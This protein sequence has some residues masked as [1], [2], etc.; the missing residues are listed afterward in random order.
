M[1]D[2]VRAAVLTGPGNIEI[3]E[4]PYPKCPE[5]GAIIKMELAGICGTDKHTYKGEV[6]QF[7]GTPAETT[8]PFPII[9]G[10]ENVGIIVEI[11]EEGRH[12]LEYDGQILNV[13]DRVV[14]CP[15]VAC[16]ECWYCKHIADYPWCDTLLGYG[17][18][19]TC[20]E[21]PHLFGGF[22]EY[23][24]IVPGVKL[25]KVPDGMPPELAVFAELFDVTYSL[26]KAKEHYTF[27]GEGFAFGDTVMIQGAGPL[28]IMHMIK[29]RML[30]ADKV[31]M[32]DTSQFR[33]DIAKEFGA[34]VTMCTKDTTEAERIEI[35][36]QHTGGRGADVVVECAGEPE[37]FNEG[38][39]MARK[40][41]T[42]LIV[43]NYVDVG[44]TIEIKPNVF[45]AKN[46]RIFGVTNH[47]V[48]GY[49]PTM[50]M[51]MRYKDVYPFEKLI[52]H[53]Y[54]LEDA[55][56]AIKMAMDYSQSM[57]VLIDPWKNR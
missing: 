7:A 16:G 56:D 8:T 24:A 40:A 10:H 6:R 28:G 55:H 46:L 3:Q 29:A 2:S 38:V 33:L 41:G 13:G 49:A 15:D 30:G 12:K 47:P 51:M 31:I 37:V 44:R 32:S 9:Q 36:R 45:C 1:K 27:G 4:F 18:A 11:S 48:G 35:V 26:D 52:T 50:R 53:R 17:N 14:M 23:M 34:D 22:A 5:G 42:Y 20:A 25:Y 57:K 43:G 19:F 39:E 54:A 21:P